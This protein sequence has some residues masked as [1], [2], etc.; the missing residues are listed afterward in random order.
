[1]DIF[2]LPVF[3]YILAFVVLLALMI[4]IRGFRMPSSH[5]ENEHIR[6]VIRKKLYMLQDNTLPEESEN[7][8]VN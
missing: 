6:S 2:D 1:M 8:Q 3:V 5:Q 7:D 4:L